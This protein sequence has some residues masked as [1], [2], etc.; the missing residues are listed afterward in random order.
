MKKTLVLCGF[1][2]LA[3]A[4]LFTAT[5]PKA[6]PSFMLVFPFLLFFVLLL[7][8]IALLLQKRGWSIG[9]SLRIGMLCAGIPLIML[10]LQSIGQLTL[11]DVLTIA[12]LFAVSYFYMSRASVSS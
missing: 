9:R 6:V 2:L 4:V 1:C 8:L 5:D 12:A 7:S 11:K 3:I 10:I